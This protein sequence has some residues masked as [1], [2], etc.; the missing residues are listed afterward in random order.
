MSYGEIAVIAG[1]SIGTVR[2]RLHNAKRLLQDA[3]RARDQSIEQR[4]IRMTRSTSSSQ[5]AWALVDREKRLDRFFR[6]VAIAAWSV[7][8]LIMLIFTVL[9]AFQLAEL[10]RGVTDGNLPWLVVFGSA[11]PFVIVVGCFSVLVAT[12][13]TIAIFLRLRTASLT[14][15]Q[16]RL[17]ALEEMIAARDTDRA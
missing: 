13:A 12:L 15:I 14:E 6:R 3:H 9:F 17:A 16:V 10:M 11:V 8:V 1:C 4:R 5:D 2:S 7:A